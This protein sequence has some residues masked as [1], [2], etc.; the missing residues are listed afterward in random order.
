M[1]CTF[2]N[3]YPYLYIH[4]LYLYYSDIYLDQLEVTKENKDP[5]N[6]SP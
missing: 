1:L 3:I 6:K 5:F 2:N 4:Y